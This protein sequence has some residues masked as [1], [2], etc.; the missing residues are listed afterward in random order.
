MQGYQGES[1]W[2]RMY[3]SFGYLNNEGYGGHLFPIFVGE[4]GSTFESET[5]AQSLAD[6]EAWFN[7][8]PHTGPVHIPV[9]R[10]F[11]F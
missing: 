8:K 2:F 1:L 7:G 10:F 6:M 3:H 4:V 11:C 9:S 5:D